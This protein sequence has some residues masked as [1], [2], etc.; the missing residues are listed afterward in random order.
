MPEV[1]AED[2]LG[3]SL[4]VGDYVVFAQK[5]YRNFCVGQI[6]KVTPKTVLI[7]HPKTNIYRTETRQDHEQVIKI[8]KEKYDE[9]MKE[10]TNV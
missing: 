6:E 4:C 1:K 3:K 7:K 5:N 10:I 9:K 2:Y 8:T